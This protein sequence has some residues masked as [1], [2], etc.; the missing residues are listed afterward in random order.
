M[1]NPDPRNADP[2][3]P[4]DIKALARA[5]GGPCVSIYVPIDAA[6][7]MSGRARFD[8]AMKKARLGLEAIGRTKEEAEAFLEPAQKLG[9]LPLFW[10]TQSSGLALFLSPAIFGHYRLPVAL[11]EFAAASDGFH[12][13]P[14]VAFLNE[15]GQFHLLR[16]SRN[17]VRLYRGTRFE[18]DKVTGIDFPAGA[19]DLLP[20][21]DFEKQLQ[22]HGS[23]SRR[24]GEL[25]HGHGGLANAN[26]TILQRYFKDI[27]RRLRRL[28][29]F[30]KIPLVLAAVDYYAAIYR[31]TNTC[32]YLLAQEIA[33]NPDNET[34]DHLHKKAWEIISANIN[35]S[36][37]EGLARYRDLKGMDFASSDIKRILPKAY[38]G[39]VDLLLVSTS[40]SIW[41]RY[42]PAKD[43]IESHDCEKAGD[44]DLSSDAAA[45]T[46]LHRGIV[47]V[48]PPD[49]MPDNNIVCALFRR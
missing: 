30:D 42:D 48:L 5:T 35:Q 9:Q 20:D 27:N 11:P 46:F 15:N 28:P 40:E 33:G 32:A 23:G 49:Q 37:K 13:K 7:P 2:F 26:K 39:K 21:T 47:H 24:K 18:M 25:F 1:T 17:Q 41:G 44:C 38:A 43:I 4:N 12:L 45:K 31:Q 6:N 3:G 14:L 36:K 19:K 10:K 34:E 16:L 8:N 29:D 22:T